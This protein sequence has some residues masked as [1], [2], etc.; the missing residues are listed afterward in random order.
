M[1][2]DFDEVIHLSGYRPEWE[3]QFED[4]QRRLADT[5][6]FE[7]T[8][9]QHI[10]ST[11]V[12]EM[13]AKPIADIMIGFVE[14]PPPLMTVQKLVGLGYEFLGEAGVAGRLY[15]RRRLS[16]AF[17]L[18]LV[19][20]QGSHWTDNIAV[21]EYLRSSASA[22]ERY[23]QAKRAAVAGGATTLLAYSV[24]KSTAIQSLLKEARG[25]CPVS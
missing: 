22:Q 18:H 8:D 12:A 23:C 13:V 25:R 15:L 7:L 5:L 1:P 10:G 2:S 16:H 3:S 21:R 9:V 6:G 14:Y 19:S 4:E 20:K 24:A 11:A 17:N